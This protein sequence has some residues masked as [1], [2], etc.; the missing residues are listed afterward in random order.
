MIQCLF[1]L[2]P[3]GPDQGSESFAALVPSQGRSP[4]AAY[5][6]GAPPTLTH[7]LLTTSNP[8]FFSEALIS[9]HSLI[10]FVL[11]LT[12]PQKPEKKKN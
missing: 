11:V 9:G 5:A 2:E 7:P 8:H 1:N 3:G 6:V 12:P 4:G 10:S